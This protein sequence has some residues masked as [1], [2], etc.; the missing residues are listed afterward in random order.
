[1]M[2]LL[3]F[4]L[5]ALVVLLPMVPALAEWR[6]KS[7]VA[8]LHIDTQDALDPPFLA[9]SFAAR[10]AAAVAAGQAQLGPS[11]LT[12]VPPQGP[13]PLHASEGRT[14]QSR[15]VWHAVGD[16]RLPAKMRFLAEVAA[17]GNLRSAP[18][19]AYR[20]LWAGQR[21]HL[22]ARGVVLRWAHGVQ[23]DIEAGCQ[24]DGR[25]SADETINVQGEVAFTLLHAP[26]VR[27][28]QAAG[29]SAGAGWSGPSI[30][31]AGLPAPV[32]WDIK[33]GRG[34]CSEALQIGARRAWNG[35]L[36]CGADVWLGAGCNANGSL[37][38]RG[39]VVTDEGCRIAG[40]VFAEGVVELGPGCSVRGS[41][42]S[43]TAVLLGAGCTVGAPDC[44]ATVAAP[45]IEVAPGVVVH[46]TLWASESGRVMK[47]QAGPQQAH[48]LFAAPDLVEQTAEPATA[49]A[50]DAVDRPERRTAA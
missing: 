4:S 35:D 8:P 40:S 26:T 20:A 7:D 42:V 50:T 39:E 37:K 36:V 25:V 43:E 21:L 44:P 10:L 6:R 3:L 29:G 24:L 1:M 17:T 9:R 19:C 33:S 5:T 34:S 41:V 15:R 46:G 32:V 2:W 13:W 22:A 28:A 48:Q 18:R 45:R 14:A 49:A 47:V 11:L 38:A 12:Q 16:A 23:V 30:F 27:F 31:P